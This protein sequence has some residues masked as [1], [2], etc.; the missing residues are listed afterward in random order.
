MSP[1]IAPSLPE[2]GVGN[3]YLFLAFSLAIIIAVLEATVL[4]NLW[5]AHSGSIDGGI[6]RTSA[7]IIIALGII[8]QSNIVR[9][10][11]SV[12]LVVMGIA[13]L[14]PLFAPSSMNWSAL[15]IL[16]LIS[17]VLSVAL[18]VMLVASKDFGK[19]FSLTR[20]K[21]SRLKKTIRMCIIVVASLGAIIATYND[22]VNLTR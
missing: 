4:M 2:T 17:A 7:P 22:V 1:E 9:Y 3:Q 18:A 12:W 5:N 10:L 14:K 11:G 20:S 13:S 21:H 15:T 16:L 6:Y 8:I 19:Q